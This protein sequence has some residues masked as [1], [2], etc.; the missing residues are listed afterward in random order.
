MIWED[1][2]DSVRYGKMAR[3]LL[4]GRVTA[5]NTHSLPPCWIMQRAGGEEEWH[6]LKEPPMMED[7]EEEKWRE[8]GRRARNRGW[9]R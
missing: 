5:R 4:K 3:G 1:A 7:G 9:W 8:D 2:L 6:L